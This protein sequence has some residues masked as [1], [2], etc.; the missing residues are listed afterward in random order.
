MSTPKPV[1]L[2]VLDG[3]G[4]R[5]ETQDN[6]I[7]AANTPNWD[8]LKRDAAFSTIDT[9]GMAVGLPEGQMGNSEVGHV[10]LGAGRIIYQDYTRISKAIAE[11]TI[12]D[13]EVI[14]AAMNDIAASGKALHLMG[15]LS[16]G[17]VHSHEGHLHGL[18]RL[19]ARKGVKQVYVHAFLDGRDTP[20]RSA[21]PSLIATQTVLEET[22]IGRIASLVGR[23]YAMDRDNRW[24]RVQPA[25]ELLTSGAAEHQ[26]DDA[27][28]GLQAA[29]ARDENDEFVAATRI[30]DA[31]TMNG[32]DAVLFFNFRADRAREITRAFIESDFDGFTRE[33]TPALSH[34]VCLTEYHA[35]FDA[36]VAYPPESIKNGLG[37]YV[38]SLGKTQLRIAETE[39]YAHVSFFF[40][41]GNDNEFAGETRKLIPSPNV[42]TYDLQPE[43]SAPEVTDALVEA[44]TKQQFDLIVCNYANPDMVG[45]T[46]VFDAAVKAVEA[47]DGC[48][49][50]VREALESVGGE[51]LVT[52]DHGNVELM[53]DHS[54]GQAHTAHTTFTVPL[55]YLGKDGANARL[56][57]GGSLQDIA[58]SLLH[59]MGVAQPAEMTGK[60]LIIAPAEGAAAA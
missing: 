17:G 10:T 34:Y 26:A 31:V 47:I 3:F 16:P 18:I 39:K 44:I 11:D 49:G 9:S 38:S 1:M 15:L 7:A 4:H 35:N 45:H 43:M 2:I 46:G 19:A 29:Y 8:A 30:G 56:A 50:R 14:S 52:A 59:M 25:Y 42:A 13:N 6:A 51:M 5:E 33:T 41:G 57:A 53:H 54:T 21:E 24:E 12:A 55:V 23:Y 36:P 27:V 60:S 20:P 22:G 28:A 58:P 40:S 48:L 32:G 37:E